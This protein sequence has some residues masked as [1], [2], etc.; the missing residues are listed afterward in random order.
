M[1]LEH[2][3]KLLHLNLRN[4]KF[5][6]NIPFQIGNLYSLENLDLSKNLLSGKLPLELGH[7]DKLETF[8]LSH[9]NLSGSIPST[10]KELMSLTSV[11]ISYN[12]LEGP[13]PNNKAF[14]EAPFEALEDNKGL[15]GNNTNIKICPIPK[16]NRSKVII[17]SVIMSISCALI[18]SFIIVGVLFICKK[19]ERHVD[20]PRQTQM[21]VTFFEAWSHNGKNVHEEI[22]EATESFS[23]KYCIGVGGFGTVYR[24]VLSTG[25][26]FA[27]KKWHE[28]GASKEAFDSEINV[29]TR[30]RHRNIIKLYGFCSHIRHSYL[31][32]EFMEEGSL[33][34][35]L[36][37]NVKAVELEWT[38]RINVVKGL[39][40][41]ISYMHHECCPPIIHRDISTKNILLD[42]DYEAHISDFGSATTLD[43][44]SSNWTPFAGTLG[45][46][47]PVSACL[48]LIVVAVISAAL[49]S[50]SQCYAAVAQFGFE[51]D[52]N[53]DVHDH[54]DTIEVVGVDKRGDHDHDLSANDM[55]VQLR[56]RTGSPTRPSSPILNK[57]VH[58]INPMLLRPPSPPPPTP[59][60]LA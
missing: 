31:V 43:L 58:M 10:F 53:H 15:C 48:I 17:F 49:A 6:G 12:Q 46:S 8:N 5:S 32:Y 1:H 38:K 7:L 14:L 19:R 28:N 23:S 36:R 22:V 37:D 34:K 13:L 33:V 18:L 24:S 29:L 27:V 9:N 56:R 2:C 50:L 20:E 57:A 51:N 40:N 45:Y 35:I 44:E 30:A 16:E 26:V 11:D 41:A 4:N 47:A 54:M 52:I 21:T 42:H 3:S 60:S 25:Q 55:K 39:A 59:S